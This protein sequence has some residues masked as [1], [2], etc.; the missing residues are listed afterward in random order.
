MDGINHGGHTISAAPSASSNYKVT[1]SMEGRYASQETIQPFT[2][3]TIELTGKLIAQSLPTILTDFLHA[4]DASLG[5]S[6]EQAKP[7]GEITL[8]IRRADPPV[9][10]A[11]IPKQAAKNLPV[12]ERAKK[13]G[14][15]RTS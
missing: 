9:S 7:I 10:V 4:E 3:S 5:L 8:T 2:F 1:V 13:A 12:Y 15:H 6:L 11:Y 14:V